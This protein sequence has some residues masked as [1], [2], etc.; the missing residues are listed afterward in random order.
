MY[1]CAYVAIY[2]WDKSSRIVHEQFCV[3]FFELSGTEMPLFSPN[4]GSL[5]KSL[6]SLRKSFIG[7][8][9]TNWANLQ[10]SC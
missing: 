2:F 6:N 5:H 4:I 3:E 7:K 10:F 1:D 9:Y 8:N